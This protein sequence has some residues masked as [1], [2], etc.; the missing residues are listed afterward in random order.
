MKY[1]VRDKAGFSLVEILVVV[2]LFGVIMGAVYTLV[3]TNQRAAYTSDDTV[4]VQQNLRIA[5]DSIS[6][7][8][9]MAGM[10]LDNSIATPIS[11]FTDNLGVT[12]KDTA[13]DLVPGVETAGS[14]TITM[15]MVSASGV[16]ARVTADAAPGATS[17]SLAPAVNATQVSDAELFSDGDAVRIVR[18]ADFSSLNATLIYSVDANPAPPANTINF[19]AAITENIKVGDVIAK[20]NTAPIV[21]VPP[22]TA[23]GLTPYPNTVL[24]SVVSNGAAATATQ[25][26]GCPANQFC[27]TRLANGDALE[28]RQIV[29]QNIADFQ[30]RYVL[31][32]NSVV[33]APTDLTLI[34]AVI[35]TIWGETRTSRLV[36]GTTPIIRQLSSEVKLRNRR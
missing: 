8:L 2:A 25:D 1:L 5:M 9:R 36:T 16:Y 13:V 12:T 23:A 7:D 11:A 18:P 20:A 30:L 22:L 24:Y 17:F 6:R 31:D 35:V 19:S 4:E 10:L 34:K 28:H 15:S 21:P 33:D 27:L 3:I 14:D 26:P 29:A 32:D